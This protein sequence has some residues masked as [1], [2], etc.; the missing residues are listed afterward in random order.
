MK[1]ENYGPT[2]EC[3]DNH[4]QTSQKLYFWVF[5]NNFKDSKGTKMA[6]PILESSIKTRLNTIDF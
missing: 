3:L 4:H 2:G 5:C 6:N 1:L